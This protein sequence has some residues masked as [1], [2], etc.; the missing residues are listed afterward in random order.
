VSSTASTLTDVHVIPVGFDGLEPLLGR[1]GCR[2]L[3][4][5][6]LERTLAVAREFGSVPV[7]GGEPAGRAIV[8]SADVPRFSAA[9]LAVAELD[10]DE[11]SDVSFGATFDGGAYLVAMRD[12]RPELLDLGAGGFPR[13]LAGAAE[14]GLEVGMLRMERRLLR[15][16]DALAMLADPLL[17]S[18]VRDVLTREKTSSGDVD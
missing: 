16:E 13:V 7:E 9:H 12:A 4:A 17:P 8:V 10:L 6:L 11:G 1:E 14:A 5:V 18:D 3:A 2:R 15:P